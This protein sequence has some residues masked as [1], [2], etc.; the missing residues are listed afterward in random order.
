MIGAPSPPAASE[1]FPARVGPVSWRASLTLTFRRSGARTV[2]A[3]RRHEGPLVVQKPLYPEGPAI[4]HTILVH[5][6]GGIAGGDSLSLALHLSR[7]SHVVLTTPAATRWY[8]AN[9]RQAWQSTTL[10]V[11]DGAIL[12]WLPQETM[13]FN[14]ADARIETQVRLTGDARYAGWDIVCLGRRA[15]GESFHRGAWRQRLGIVRDGR[16]IW[17][18]HGTLPADDLVR[19]SAAGLGGCS[20]FGGFVVAAGVSPEGLIAACRAITVGEDARCGITATPDI[21]SARYLGDNA[22]QARHYFAALWDILRPWY[23]GQP[24]RRPRLWS[25]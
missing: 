4:C 1:P 5:T 15:S 17:G 9:G 18:E 14:E 7:D 16:P 12:E 13:L 2:L 24:A 6:P 20:V 22:E 3:E 10:D 23:G 25:T 21:V 19:R 8:K 11:D